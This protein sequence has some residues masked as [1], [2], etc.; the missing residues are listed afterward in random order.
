MVTRNGHG[1]PTFK[2]YRGSDN[3]ERISLHHQA[4]IPTYQLSCCGNI[5]EWGLDV[6]HS[7]SFT[8]DLQVW[9]PSPTVDDSTGTG[10]Y[11]LVGNNRFTSISLRSGV[12][13]VTPSPQDYIQFVCGDVLGFYVEDIKSSIF[14]YPGVVLQTS[15]GYLTS[16]LLWFASINHECYYLSKWRLSLLSWEQWWNLKHL[17]TS[18][19]CHLN[20]Y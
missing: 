10:C 5:T 19:T 14:P 2:D 18:S 9:R 7:Y 12:A 6:A 13:I 15:P 3:D 4:I 20:I 16:E 17:N 8:L 11:S 1:L